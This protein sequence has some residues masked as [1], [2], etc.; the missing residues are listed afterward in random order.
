M[1]IN[2][3]IAGAIR[4]KAGRGSVVPGLNEKL[5]GRNHSLDDYFTE[6]KVHIR[7]RVQSNDDED[8]DN[9]TADG[10]FKCSERTG[11]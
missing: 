11:V 1:I 8:D 7:E 4:V 5:T 2:R 10:L 9:L 6:K 3:K